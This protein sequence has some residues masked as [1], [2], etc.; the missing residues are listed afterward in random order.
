MVPVTFFYSLFLCPF[1]LFFVT[2]V[3]DDV[4]CWGNL[5]KQVMKFGKSLGN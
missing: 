3:G 1:S 5:A 4:G 2:I